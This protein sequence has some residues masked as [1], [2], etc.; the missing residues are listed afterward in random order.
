MYEACICVRIHAIQSF[1][2]NYLQKENGAAN[3]SRNRLN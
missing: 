3:T 2:E 1:I